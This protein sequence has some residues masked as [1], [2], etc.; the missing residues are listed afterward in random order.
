MDVHGNATDILVHCILEFS[1]L[2]P[3]LFVHGELHLN[4]QPICYVHR[5]QVSYVFL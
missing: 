3:D 1:V 5:Y 4:E 2:V